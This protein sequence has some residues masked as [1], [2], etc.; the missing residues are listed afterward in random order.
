MVKTNAPKRGRA[1]GKSRPLR[2][3]SQ[4]KGMPTIVLNKGKSK[5][6]KVAASKKK[7]FHVS[8]KPQVKKPKA[9]A[10]V[11]T[12]D[13]DTASVASTRGRRNATDSEAGTSK[14]PNEPEKKG[15]KKTQKT[16][17]RS[18]SPAT[19]RLSRSSS[20]NSV[21]EKKA[22][23][24]KVV[25]GGAEKGKGKSPVTNPKH[26]I[27]KFFSKKTLPSKGSSGSKS[28]NQ[29]AKKDAGNEEG[30]SQTEL[31][32]NSSPDSVNS[33]SVRSSQIACDRFEVNNDDS[34][35]V[36]DDESC[37]GSHIEDNDTQNPEPDES[38][39]KSVNGNDVDG[40]KFIP[41]LTK[42]N[43]NELFPSD[44]SS[45]RLRSGSPASQKST[46]SL[47]LL[48]NSPKATASSSLSFTT[49]SESGIRAL[50]NGKL[51][52][53]T[54]S[55][56][57][58]SGSKK[59]KRVYAGMVNNDDK[60]ED[61]RSDFS[62]E[63]SSIFSESD[64]SS[65]IDAF[66]R[67]QKNGLD[68]K[69]DSEDVPGSMSND[70]DDI[71]L[72][73]ISS[74]K[75]ALGSRRKTL[76]SRAPPVSEAIPKSNDILNHIQSDWDSDGETNVEEADCAASKLPKEG[77]SAFDELLSNS[78]LLPPSADKDSSSDGKAVEKSD[79]VDSCQDFSKPSENKGE[80]SESN[81]KQDS[82]TKFD[83]EN[84][85]RKSEDLVDIVEKDLVD[86]LDKD[87][88]DA[89]ENYTVDV[90]ARSE[91]KQD[92]VQDANTFSES[93]KNSIESP[94]SS[95]P[96]TDPDDSS[97][98]S[99]KKIPEPIVLKTSDN[100]NG[101]ADSVDFV[102]KKN[103][104]IDFELLRRRT[105][106]SMSFNM[107]L[108]EKNQSQ[109]ILA[110][111][112]NKLHGKASLV[113]T[114]KAVR[115][116][117]IPKTVTSPEKGLTKP[118]N[119][120][121]KNLPIVK[122]MM[123]STQNDNQP[124]PKHMP[125]SIIVSALPSACSSSV[126][127]NILVKK[128]PKQSP[129][130]S[131][132]RE[133]P[134]VCSPKV[135]LPASSS[136]VKATPE[137]RN[138]NSVSNVIELE[139]T[140]AVSNGIPSSASDSTLAATAKQPSDVEET[141]SSNSKT[142]DAAVPVETEDISV[143]S[144]A[145]TPIGENSFEYSTPLS[146]TQKIDEITESA[147]VASERCKTP[148]QILSELQ[149]GTE[150]TPD[151]GFD[152]ESFCLR[153]SPTPTKDEFNQSNSS[154]VL[155]PVKESSSVPKKVVSNAVAEKNS[156]SVDVGKGN[157]NLSDNLEEIG[158]MLPEENKIIELSETISSEVSRA[159]KPI[160]Q[161]VF[162]KSSTR[163][164]SL[165]ADCNPSAIAFTNDEDIWVVKNNNGLSTKDEH[166]LET[167]KNS[168][169]VSEDAKENVP[170]KCLESVVNPTVENQASLI[171]TVMKSDDSSNMTVECSNIPVK[172][173][174]L[175]SPRLEADVERLNLKINVNDIEKKRR[176]ITEE[177]QS[178]EKKAIKE[179]VLSSLGLQSVAAAAAAA[180]SVAG[181]PSKR[182]S[183]DGL[184]PSSGRLKAV[185]KVPKD[186]KKDKKG[187]RKPLRMV[188]K[189][190]KVHSGGIEDTLGQGRNSDTDPS[191][192]IE[193][194]TSADL[195]GA[196]A[197]HAQG[198]ATNGALHE[199]AT[200][201]AI[202]SD[203]KAKPGT[204]LVIPE[205][206]SSFSIHPGRLCSD[207][208][209]YCFG[210]FGLLDTPCHVAQLKGRER[211][212]KIMSV[213]THLALDSCLCD[214]CI[215]HVDR[216]ANCP[217]SK[218]QTSHRKEGK[219]KFEGSMATCSVT[220]CAQPARHSLRKKW[221]L[222]IKKSVVKKCPI[223]LELMQQHLPLPLCPE[224]FSYMEYFMVC[225]LCKRR[226]SRS[227]MY[228]LNNTSEINTCLEH[229]GIP[230]RLSDKL[231]V[232]KLCRY[233]ATLRVK[234]PG[235]HFNLSSNQREFFH[236]YRKRILRNHDI[237]VSD[238]E[239]DDGADGG[240]RDE[241]AS[242]EENTSHTNFIPSDP[243][244][245]S[246][247]KGKRKRAS[248]NASLPVDAAEAADVPKKKSR[249]GDQSTKSKDKLE[250]AKTV[251]G[252][253]RE[254]ESVRETVPPV[255]ISVGDITQGR[256]HKV[257]RPSKY[258]QETENA[259]SMEFV[260]KGLAPFYPAED[261]LALHAKFQFEDKPSENLMWEKCTSTL[262]FDKDTKKLWQELQRPYGSQSSFLRHLV[263]MER[264]WREGE[265]V[266]AADASPKATSYTRSVQNRLKAYGSTITIK[267]T[268]Q[269]P[270]TASSVSSA[271]TVSQT[272][273]LVASLAA[274]TPA[275]APA[276]PPQAV[277]PVAT[278]AHAAP[279]KDL[280]LAL[281]GG[282]V[283]TAAAAA[284]AV[285][286]VHLSSSLSPSGE[287][288]AGL[289]PRA[290][291]AQQQAQLK[292]PAKLQSK[293]V[294]GKTHQG[295]GL[296][297]KA[298]QSKAQQGKTQAVKA[299]PVRQVPVKSQPLILGKPV[300]A[301]QKPVAV[302]QPALQVTSVTSAPVK[303]SQA[304]PCV[305]TVRLTVK[306]P[307][308]V[309]EVPPTSKQT[310][311]PT[312]LAISLAGHSLP[313]STPISMTSALTITP[314]PS[315]KLTADKSQSAHGKLT[316]ILPKPPVSSKSPN[317]SSSFTLTSRSTSSTWEAASPPSN[318]TQFIP[319]SPVVNLTRSISLTAVPSSPPS[320]PDLHPINSVRP[321]RSPSGSLPLSTNSITV[322]T[323]RTSPGATSVSLPVSSNSMTVTPSR[324]SSGSFVSIVPTSSG[325]AAFSKPSTLSI[326]RPASI[327]PIYT[328]QS[329]PAPVSV[330]SSVASRSP[331]TSS[332]IESEP[333][334]APAGKVHVTAGGKS[335]ALTISQF[336]KL[337]ALRQQRRKEKK[338]TS[339]TTS[340]V[341]AKDDLEVVE[342]HD[343]DTEM[344]HSPLPTISAVVS[345][346]QA[347]AMWSDESRLSDSDSSM[348]I[349]VSSPVLEISPLIS[350]KH[351]ITVESLP[352]IPK[353]LTVTQIR[354]ESPTLPKTVAASGLS[355]LTI[356]RQ[357]CQ[358]PV[359]PQMSSQA[360]DIFPS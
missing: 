174:G 282:T 122:P 260:R 288:G 27:L 4:S 219:G 135:P 183:Q 303:T 264:F 280:A 116:P 238:S 187:N 315:V 286:A 342:V 268:P 46:R 39:A 134:P 156:V 72:G 265:L 28:A 40:E 2:S 141:P 320:V 178:P 127:E 212:M 128:S 357:K 310:S 74:A 213:E 234:H 79:V 25:K 296:Q 129:G 45:S 335:F 17:E 23:A 86:A 344:Q 241:D 21:V 192:R 353:A 82:G 12:E 100:K 319:M 223:D 209:S 359:A 321:N 37:R 154:I 279:V 104:R 323:S 333:R 224:H 355:S 146:E 312:Q 196:P 164:R 56:N 51:K 239:E 155:T 94:A 19:T 301:P 300:M 149:S 10:L 294:Q 52:R 341:S 197:F 64:S 261:E 186:G 118:D 71:G 250:T 162:K 188:F 6:V 92:A 168:I 283:L 352:K 138:E 173:P 330:T 277:Q 144:A 270:A 95:Q 29:A 18:E 251:R 217:S 179:R 336:K 115:E 308:P 171:E 248:S 190:G 67:L 307:T 103:P 257:G 165:S 167:G 199:D 130:R 228:N 102:A 276:P 207:V 177:E 243:S 43:I 121:N 1:T 137:V 306:A 206:S 3:D 16:A 107:D 20:A 203:G 153:L 32:E 22:E 358:T 254:R 181:R 278:A 170:E 61:S 348:S 356:T 117:I 299:P 266:L 324:G 90:E 93:T 83:E 160:L 214:A 267:S 48:R 349:S 345:G 31:P 316:P 96:S 98:D 38:S 231:F 161:L 337:Q 114:V 274:P 309:Q 126:K 292:Q 232:C 311:A 120:E 34:S 298:V 244:E 59:K 237:E 338:V 77:N 69:M 125:E 75:T 332:A 84:S 225:G 142:V 289:A 247:P 15:A 284:A 201:S 317:T 325:K 326:N 245:E 263:L 180:A 60:I 42:K 147:N 30:E 290:Q 271:P 148:D 205:K 33:G 80:I 119:S 314:E 246:L 11:E 227:H 158:A 252:R 275:P 101:F 159:E 66:P 184:L 236:S 304:A 329:L 108:P 112:P 235:S 35:A 7:V 172:Q 85:V 334:A 89:L 152:E 70:E 50:R 124:S 44:D 216:K 258:R 240:D 97:T 191:F 8:L 194:N 140:K 255:T 293:A 262:Q 145:K 131:P 5:K 55:E 285:T 110:V 210:K 150:V 193:G 139:E 226:L 215:R 242:A 220:N 57:L 36:D 229:D 113:W 198:I 58:F 68:D 259:T 200:A 211:Q 14:S 347:K 175:L 302:T 185:I 328:S 88:V 233:Y 360:L 47:V 163:P 87:I 218:P 123:E 339:T 346:D 182:R 256:S 41:K 49:R 189:N 54:L 249:H 63:Q 322:T 133:T 305:P 151:K 269:P 65:F 295:K 318:R 221:Y 132:V 105:K 273:T 106:R 109:R 351:E 166:R 81:Q 76:A 99:S 281:T 73:G 272:P 291:Q 230:A 331:A 53:S 222:K 202:E 195:S 340:S 208:C 13:S 111:E 287:V 343:G 176:E 157:A 26:G 91:V 78:P 313:I 62:D 297:W 24:K 169:V 253:S 143:G 350:G 354:K 136:T 204:N 327:T 9:K